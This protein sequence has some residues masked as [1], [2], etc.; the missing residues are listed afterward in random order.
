MDR[1][2]FDALSLERRYVVENHGERKRV[3]AC[4]RAPWNMDAVPPDESFVD[5]LQTLILSAFLHAWDP[6]VGI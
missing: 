2:Q 5:D 4:A 3:T 1:L 6:L